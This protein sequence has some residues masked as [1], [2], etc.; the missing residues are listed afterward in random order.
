MALGELTWLEQRCRHVA[1]ETSASC[2]ALYA[3]LEYR[4]CAGTDDTR[5]RA[6]VRPWPLEAKRLSSPEIKRS[7]YQQM[8]QLKWRSEGEGNVEK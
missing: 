3:Q 1:E 5:Y 7:E 6:A 2:I 8:S 4:R